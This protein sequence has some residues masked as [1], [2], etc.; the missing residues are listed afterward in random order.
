MPRLFVAV[1]LPEAI[2]DVAVSVG[3]GLPGARWLPR[4]QLHVTLAFIGEVD[5]G[6]VQDVRASLR[7]VDVP[8]FELSLRGLGHFPPRG[9]PRVAWAGLRA[10]EPLALL[11]RR[12]LRQLESAGCEFERRKFHPHVTLAR[13]SDTP[14]RRLADWLSGNSFFETGAFEVLEFHLYSSILSSHGATH[15][16]EETYQLSSP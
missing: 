13:L 12:V 4:E 10:S 9:E 2:K 11:H 16:V 15:Q 14:P 5:G 7:G 6:M 3:F 8:P 1:D